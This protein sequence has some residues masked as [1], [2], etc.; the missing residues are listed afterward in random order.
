MINIREFNKAV[1]EYD[2]N[3]EIKHRKWE[4]ARE[5]ERVKAL[6]KDMER[7]RKASFNTKKWISKNRERFNVISAAWRKR[8]PKKARQ[9]VINWKKRNPEKALQYVKNWQRN[10]PEYLKQY[11]IKNREKVVFKQYGLSQEQMQNLHKIQNGKCGICNC[12][13]KPGHFTH[14]DHNHETGKPR[15]LLCIRCNMGFG[16]FRD[17]SGLLKKALAYAI[18]HDC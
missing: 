7:R 10:H 11:Y 4:E 8:N 16:Y 6:E 1:K 12:I 18:K 13:L 9:A 5:A 3:K 17:N 15:G 2:R 14:I